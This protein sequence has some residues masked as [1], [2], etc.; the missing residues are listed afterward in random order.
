MTWLTRVRNSLSLIRKRD[1]P[2]N[3]WMKC[4][5][6]SEMLFARAYEENLSVCPRCDHH[7]RI[8]AV[9]RM[10]QLLDPD[11]T[12][13]PGPKVKEDPLRFR[14]SKNTPIGSRP[15]VPII[16]IPMP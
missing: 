8:G 13:V 5:S 16:L 11:F 15:R 2:D 14:D 12:I 7:G 3:L 6:C 1:T 4:P 10:G 9:A